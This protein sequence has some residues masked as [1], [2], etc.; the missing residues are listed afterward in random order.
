MNQIGLLKQQLADKDE[1]MR[2]M[3]DAKNKHR[4]YYEDKLSLEIEA[5]ERTKG[6]LE[7]ANQRLQEMDEEIETLRQDNN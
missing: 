3:G 2:E 5:T 1:E 6:K 4:D 7:D